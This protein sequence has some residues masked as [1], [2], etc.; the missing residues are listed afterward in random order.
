LAHCSDVINFHRY[1]IDPD[2]LESNVLYLKNIGRRV[3]KPVLC[4]ET[5]TGSIT[6]PYPEE[7][8]RWLS[9]HKSEITTFGGPEQHKKNVLMQTAVMEKHGIGYVLPWLVEGIAA[10]TCDEKQSDL[11]NLALFR[12]DGT[13]KAAGSVLSWRVRLDA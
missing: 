13:A 11:G 9:V 8:R 1:D 12:P 3:G 5:G 4:T 7:C 2:I 6:E 10:D